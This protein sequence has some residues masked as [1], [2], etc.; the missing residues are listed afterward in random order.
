MAKMSDFLLLGNLA[1]RAG[2]GRKV[3]WDAEKMKC[4]NI[5]ELNQYLRREYRQGWRV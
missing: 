3:E 4:S 5:P 2:V 1:E